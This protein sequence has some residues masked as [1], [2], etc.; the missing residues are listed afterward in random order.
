MAQIYRN[1][2]RGKNVFKDLI[3]NLREIICECEMGFRRLGF[4]KRRT[5]GAVKRED[6]FYEFKNLSLD[7]DL[8]CSSMSKSYEPPPPPDLKQATADV[9]RPIRYLSQEISL[10]LIFFGVLVWS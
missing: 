8:I 10:Y 9:R 2:L 7:S 6:S 4:G 3:N 5:V 1:I